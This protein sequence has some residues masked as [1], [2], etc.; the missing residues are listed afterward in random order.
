MGQFMLPGGNRMHVAARYWMPSLTVV[1]LLFMGGWF[2]SNMV[3]A[4][5]AGGAFM[6][7]VTVKGRVIKVHGRAVRVLVPASTVVRDGQK[8][9]LPA[10]TI[11]LTQTKVVAGPVRTLPGGTVVRTVPRTVLVTETVPTTVVET[12]TD[13]TSTTYTVTDTVTDT[14]TETTTVTT[15]TAATS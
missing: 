9:T 11:D 7:T 1:V 12:T 15:T 4:T 14:S 5:N 6:T 13:Q 2:T 10:R 3:G 8:V